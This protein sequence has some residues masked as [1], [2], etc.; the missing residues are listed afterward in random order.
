M[1][2]LTR[3]KFIV[4][5]Q[6]F[7]NF[8]LWIKN[9]LKP[10]KLSNFTSTQP[11]L[12]GLGRNPDLGL[13]CIPDLYPGCDP[14][15]GLGC[16]PNFDPGCVGV[17]SRCWAATQRIWARKSTYY[18]SYLLDIRKPTG[19]V[20]F[21]KRPIKMSNQSQTVSIYTTIEFNKTNSQSSEIRISTEGLQLPRTPPTPAV[22]SLPP[23]NSLTYSQRQKSV[24]PI[25]KQKKFRLFLPGRRNFSTRDKPGTFLLRIPATAPNESLRNSVQHRRRSEFL[26]SLEFLDWSSTELP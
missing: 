19:T 3:V 14:D 23:Y 22:P 15:F 5:C 4:I 9:H 24:F 16:V 20:P 11:G 13:G 17:R 21:N 1:H 25:L 2:F 7:S 8:F 26:E 18:S 10:R 6:S 12:F